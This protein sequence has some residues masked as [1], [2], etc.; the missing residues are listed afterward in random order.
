[1]TPLRSTYGCIHTAAALLFSLG[2]A[3]P[4]F[5][6]ANLISAA[7]AANSMAMP[8]PTELRL[9]FSEGIEIKFTKVKVTGPNKKAIEA[10]PAK[11]DPADNTVLIVPLTAPLPDGKYAVDW[12]AVSVDG[13][14][15]KGSYG[16]ESMR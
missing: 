7:P 6:H 13:H 3:T 5:A 1:M 14:K 15:T 4:A 8:P 9:K 12:Q 16:F 10:G 2:L 11:L